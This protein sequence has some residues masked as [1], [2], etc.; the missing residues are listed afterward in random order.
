MDLRRILLM[1]AFAAG[2]GLV[3]WAYFCIMRR[4]IGRLIVGRRG[5][6][7]YLALALLRIV[8]F[9]GGILAALL[10]DELCLFPYLVMFLVM[11]TVVVRRARAEGVLSPPPSQTE[12]R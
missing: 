3:G 6:G 5:V 12:A 2:G 4:A 10:L 9:A 8:L 7:M 1:V 11:R